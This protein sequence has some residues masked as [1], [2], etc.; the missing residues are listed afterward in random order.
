MGFQK[1]ICMG[2]LTR[3]PEAR[4][5]AKGMAVTEFTVAVNGPRKEDE[6]YFGTVVTFGSTAEACARYLS[7]GSPVLVEGK[8]KNDEWEDKQTGQKRTKTRI[9]AEAVQFIGRSDNSRQSGQ[10]DQNSG[11]TARRPSP[12]PAPRQEARTAPP[13]MPPDPAT[14]HKYQPADCPQQPQNDNSDIPF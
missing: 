11:Y 1:F 9:V 6:A 3:D 14:Y 2:N 10:S 13:P 5:T 12:A 4:H 8:L 7:K